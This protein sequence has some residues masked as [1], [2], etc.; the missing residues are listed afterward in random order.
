MLS[1]CGAGL[2][3]GSVACRDLVGNAE[4]PPGTQSP[5]TYNTPAGALGMYRGTKLDVSYMTDPVVREA[6]ALTDEL[7]NAGV[8]SS[9]LSIGAIG[10]PLDE[11]LLPESQTDDTPGSD[12]Y[13]V[14]QHLRGHA[15]ES[16]GLMRT[17]VPDSLALLGEMYAVEGYAEVMLAELFCSGVPLSTLDFQQDFTYKPSSSQ[18]EVYQHAIALLDSA[19]AI[20]SDRTTVLWFASVEKGRALT[21]LG[22]YAQAAQAVSAVPDTFRYQT[23]FTWTPVTDL[24]FRG[25]TVTNREGNNGMPFSSRN[26][27]RAAVTVAGTNVFGV[28]L[29]TPTKYPLNTPSS[30][31]LASGVEARLIEAEADL[32]AGG[33]QWLTIL[34]ALRTDGS[35]APVYTR[36][37][38]NGIQN[39]DGTVAQQGSPCPSGVVDVKWGW[40]TGAYLIP[41]SVL[42]NTAPTCPT[43][44]APGVPCTDTTSYIGLPPLTDP[45]VAS[46]PNGK[47]AFDVRLELLFQERAYWL[48][49]TGHR[50]GD[51][52]RLVRN[53]GRLQN[54]VYPTGA[55]YGGQGRYGNDVT[56]PIPISERPNPLFH[57]CLD[58]EA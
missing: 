10:D 22:Q 40:G 46:L 42:T 15:L 55:Y 33:S 29:F 21:D 6:G 49:L 43:A 12:L 18:T 20:S 30:I 26:D 44:S 51:L 45:G 28:A 39:T 7:G 14:L 57:G 19:R 24:A 9:P 37:C 2:L 4:L 17:Y 3:L 34:N 23:T 8:G 1:L 25:F 54:T 52:R 56:L 41:A 38:Q 5:S 11:R 50:Q 27:P 16:I 35:S 36:Q 48:F 32:R 47:S 58:R 53:D 13:S 31:V